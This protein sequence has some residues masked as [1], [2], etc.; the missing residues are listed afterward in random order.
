MKK[1]KTGYLVFLKRLTGIHFFKVMRVTVF[2]ILLGVSN[3]FASSTYSQSTKF[4]F[5]L[6]NISLDQ[7]FE[8]I[9][10]NS[11]FNIFYKNSQVDKNLRVDIAASEASVESI[12][13]QAFEEINL[14]FKILDRQIVI[15][16]KQNSPEEIEAEELN[17]V[18]PQQK[19]VSGK[20]TDSNGQTLPGVTIIVA[21]TTVGTVT[22][23]DGQFSLSVPD[24]ARTLKFSFVGMKA[25]EIEVGNQTIFNVVMNEEA[26][27]LEEVVAIGYGVQS[28]R[29][30][31]GSI[32]KVGSEDIAGKQIVSF[33]QALQGQAAGVNVTQGTGMAGSGSVVRIRGI[34][35]INAS[36]DPLYVVD[37]I[38]ISQDMFS[39]NATTWGMNPNPLSSINPNDIES[40]E[41]LKDAAACGIYGSRGSN[42][43]IIITTK[44]AKGSKLE[45]NFST[46]HGLS[47]PT[48]DPNVVGT[49]DWMQM[50][51]EAWEND[52]NTGV[53]QNLPGNL[54]WEQAKQNNTDWWKEITHVGYKKE[55]NLSASF[56]ISNKLK[57]Y[58][59]G[60]YNNN[61]SYIKHNAF[62]RYTGKINLSY[63]PS[64]KLN[65]AVS[66]MLAN[67][68]TDLVG[69]PWSGGT[70]AAMGTALPIYPIYNEDETYFK[71]AGNDANPLM[72]SELMDVYNDETR[73]INSLS[74]NYAPFKKLSFSFNGAVDYLKFLNNGFENKYLRSVNGDYTWN[75]RTNILNY[76]YNIIAN[77]NTTIGENEFVFML[78]NEMQ[79]SKTTG[80]RNEYDYD[81][82]SSN[83]ENII[84]YGIQE[85]RFLSCFGRINYKYKDRYIAQASLRF[86]GSSRF[87][88]NNKFGTF[89]TLALGWIASEEEFVK[90]I[91]SE[92]ILSFLKFKASY[93][94]TGNSDIP[95]YEHIGTYVTPTSNSSYYND[96][97]VRYPSKY[98]NPDLKWEITKNLD[99]AIETQL[100]GGRV[101]AEV[102]YFL[103]N[104]E[105]VFINVSV[106]QTTGYREQWKNIAKIRNE[107]LE[108]NIT[109]RN[110]VGNS[111][112]DFRWTTK[113]N[114]ATIDN[115]VADLGGLTSQEI[116]GG[117]NDTRIMLGY[118]IG[119]MRMVRFSR[120]D[121][122]DGRPIYLDREGNETKTYIFAGENGYAMPAGKL[123]PDFTGGVTNTFEY[124]GFSLSALFTFSYGAQLYDA[125]A[126]RQMTLMSNW[127][128]R[129][130]GF[131]R[132]QNP[133]DDAKYPRLTLD[134]NNWGA[135]EQWFNTSMW[136]YDASYIRLKNLRFAYDLPSRFLNKLHLS[137]GQISITGTNLLTFTNF[138][139][140]DPEVAR[141]F[142]DARDRNMSP[143]AT[144]LTVPQE[145]IYSL[146][147]NISF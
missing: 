19:T 70:G 27:G 50:Y 28:K 127:N 60:S 52:G 128:F 122:E 121:S 3:V 105:D 138:P 102:A 68:K 6:K 64:P 4:T 93:G 78:G 75:S 22:D 29:E 99:L 76:N 42:G 73:T 49:E 146:G 95:N 98:S 80:E 57:A 126:K 147:L 2:L 82:E 34:A 58:V 55:Y 12:L 104:S 11:E 14:D 24:D 66:T 13:T 123:I 46:K 140:I 88:A 112:G 71:G 10:N 83:P 5:H 132:W 90:N 61:E 7:L 39:L 45:I 30:I 124:K 41:V 86:D 84:D 106:S 89:P 77:Y 92:D 62:E 17:Q 131:D 53:P 109:T 47:T 114:I 136:I 108:F 38:P 87:G 20:V 37:G 59:S 129:T 119:T 26:I 72:V 130:D 21:G 113:F 81:P 79:Y 25:K 91:I 9:Q 44:K 85:W 125:A 143:N 56:G 35:S 97:A 137:S 32:S 110:I 103:K 117:A 63:N 74:L 134:G 69:D 101:A 43:V 65:L 15:F 116:G 94:Y 1:S 141:D 115:E 48:K 16:S 118:P 54:T 96:M 111:P 133:G 120:I 33:E 107:G 135:S 67:T 144:Y 145:K 142:N 139:G 8:E 18:Q 40:I 51:Q 31:V 100:W 23:P 36:G